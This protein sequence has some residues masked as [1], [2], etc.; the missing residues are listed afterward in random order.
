[1]VTL[2]SVFEGKKILLCG[3]CFLSIFKMAPRGQYANYCCS[4]EVRLHQLLLHRLVVMYIRPL[5]CMV[6]CMD[7]YW[8][9]RILNP[10]SSLWLWSGVISRAQ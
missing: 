7:H 1:M 2:R 9:Q 8:P 3:R 5:V 10:L 4:A 6:M